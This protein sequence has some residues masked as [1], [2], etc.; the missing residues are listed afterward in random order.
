MGFGVPID[1]WLKTDL[2]EWAEELLGEKRLRE[3][4][5]F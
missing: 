4:R 5:F 3:Q 1:E 2:R